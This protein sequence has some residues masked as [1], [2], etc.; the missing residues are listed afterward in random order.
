MLNHVLL[1][2]GPASLVFL[3]EAARDHGQ[4]MRLA[5]LGLAGVGSEDQSWRAHILPHTGLGNFEYSQEVV[6]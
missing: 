5:M 6:A 3:P 4:K 1:T 2:K